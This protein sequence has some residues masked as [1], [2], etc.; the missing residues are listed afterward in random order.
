M[1][2]TFTGN[3]GASGIEAFE[4]LKD[5]YG[6]CIAAS[7]KVSITATDKDYDNVIRKLEDISTAK[8]VVCFCEG[9]TVTNLLKATKRLGLSGQ[10]VFI[11]R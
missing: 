10:F 8:V 4:T 6:I 2:F 3:Y 5:E 9:E 1:S 11:G 7:E